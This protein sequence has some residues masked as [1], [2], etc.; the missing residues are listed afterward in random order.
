MILNIGPTKTWIIRRHRGENFHQFI[1]DYEK[2]D[3]TVS[4][5]KG[6]RQ[7]SSIKEYEELNKEIHE[8]SRLVFR[9]IAASTNVR[10]MIS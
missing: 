3:Y 5:E 4:P 1:V 7:T 2:P 6:L 8:V 9:D 10:G